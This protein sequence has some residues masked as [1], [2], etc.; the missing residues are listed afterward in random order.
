M[1]QTNNKEGTFLKIRPL[2][3][4]ALATWVKM[5]QIFHKAV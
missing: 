5:W 2:V 1:Q 3:R 4:K